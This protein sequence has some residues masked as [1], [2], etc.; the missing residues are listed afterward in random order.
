MVRQTLD[1]SSTVDA[2]TNHSRDLMLAIEH[3]VVLGVTA[4][5]RDDLL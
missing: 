1:M 5:T 4:A 2:L 3:E